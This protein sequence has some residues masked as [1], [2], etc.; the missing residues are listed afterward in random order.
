MFKEDASDFLYRL[1]VA[2]DI[3]VP[4][5]YESFALHTK[6]TGAGDG[7][8][9]VGSAFRKSPA[10]VTNDRVELDAGA[11]VNAV[12]GGQDFATWFQ[13]VDAGWNAFA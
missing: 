12:G 7:H 4:G 11:E 9:A 1:R 5:I 3:C 8:Y 10:V 6:E 13:Q 2:L